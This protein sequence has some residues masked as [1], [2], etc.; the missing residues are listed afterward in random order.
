ME[1]EL[2]FTAIIHYT[3]DLA[4]L[5]KEKNDQPYLTIEDKSSNKASFQAN[6]Y[7][8]RGRKNLTRYY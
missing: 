4:Q 3:A 2:T 7:E 6:E 1:G 8:P 5:I